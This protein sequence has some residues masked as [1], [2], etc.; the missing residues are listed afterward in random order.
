MNRGKRILAFMLSLA[1]IFPTPSRTEAA[2]M[3]QPSPVE[4]EYTQG[5]QWMISVVQWRDQNKDNRVLTNNSNILFD[6]RALVTETEVDGEA[7]YRVK[8]GY[9]SYSVFDTVEA[10]NPEKNDEAIQYVQDSRGYSNISGLDWS[11]KNAKTSKEEYQFPDNYDTYI[12]PYIKEEADGLYLT[13]RKITAEEAKTAELGTDELLLYK[14]DEK[15]E[16]LAYAMDKGY[17][18]FLIKDLGQDVIMNTCYSGSTLLAETS[19]SLLSFDQYTMT[20]VPDDLAA[21]ETPYTMGF[22]WGNYIKGTVSTRNP[23]GA[24]AALGEAMKGLLKE[25]VSVKVLE[26]GK[27]EATFTLADDLGTATGMDMAVSRNTDPHQDGLNTITRMAIALDLVGTSF[28]EERPLWD[29]SSENKTF[30][31]TFDNFLEGKYIRIKDTKTTNY[32]YGRLYLTREPQYANIITETDAA[33][34]MVLTIDKSYVPEYD[35]FEA[36][37]THRAEESSFSL[38]MQ[39]NIDSFAEGEGRYTIY[40]YKLKDKEGNTLFPTGNFTVDI[41]VPTDYKEESTCYNYYIEE[42]GSDGAGLP[43]DAELITIGTKKYIRLSVKDL[44]YPYIAIGVVDH[45]IPMAAEKISALDPGFYKVRPILGYQ[46]STGIPPMSSMATPVIDGG[47][48]VLEVTA[49]GQKNL[50][51][52]LRGVS[53]LGS[54]GYVYEWYTYEGEDF[55]TTNTAEALS[56]LQWGDL[57][58]DAQKNSNGTQQTDDASVQVDGFTQTLGIYYPRTIKLSLDNPWPNDTYKI[59]VVVPVMNGFTSGGLLEGVKN[60]S[61]YLIEDSV[62]K[63]DGEELKTYTEKYMTYEKSL[64]T[65]LIYRVEWDIKENGR[66]D[67][68]LSQVLAEIK[69]VEAGMAE[70][71]DQAE[72]LNAFNKL[73]DAWVKA[74]GGDQD[75]R[76]FPN[77]TYGVNITVKDHNGTEQSE[78][79]DSFKSTAYLKATEDTM[80]LTLYKKEGAAASV[81]NILY[82]EKDAE[83]IYDSEENLTGFVLK[84]P[85]TN[86]DIP[87]TL[88]IKD[89]IYTADVYVSMRLQEEDVISDGLKVLND[90][91][92]QLEAEVKQGSYE[93]VS[94]E[95][96]NAALESVRSLSAGNS[97]YDLTESVINAQREAL[98]AE[99]DALVKNSDLNSI[100]QAQLLSNTP[101]LEELLD[102]LQEADEEEEEKEKPSKEE[103]PGHSQETGGT[104]SRPG[105]SESG[106]GTAGSEEE[107]PAGDAEEP[108]QEAPQEDGQET[109]DGEDAS[110]ED[111]GNTSEDEESQDASE[112]EESQ[113]SSEDE[114]SQDTSE[115]E[116]ASGDSQDDEAEEDAGEDSQASED[117]SEEDDT[118][119]GEAAVLSLSPRKRLV[120]TAASPSNAIKLE[121]AADTATPPNAVYANASYDIANLP[122][123]N[124][125]VD[126]VLRQ[127]AQPNEDSMGNDAIRD[128]N[129]DGS[130]KQVML[131]VKQ[132]GGEKKVYLHLEF[133]AMSY[134]LNGKEKTGHLLEM[135][136]MENLK[137]NNWNDAD[138]IP[139]V[140]TVLGDGWDADLPAGEKYPDLLVFDIT[141]W[142]EKRTAEI[143]VKV[144]VP[145]MEASAE[146]P[147]LLKFYWNTLELVE[148]VAGDGVKDLQDAIEIAKARLQDGTA[149][150]KA[151]YAALEKS[152][153]AASAL[154]GYT[155][156]NES[157]SS[158]TANRLIRARIKAL[159]KTAAALV[160]SKLEAADNSP[161]AASIR[162]ADSL[163]SGDYTQETWTTM[164][165]ALKKA[166]RVEQNAGSS[167]EEINEVMVELLNTMTSLEKRPDSGKKDD[168]KVDVPDGYYSVR[169]RLWHS[170]MDKASMGDPAIEGKA[171]VH[172]EGED[173]TMRLV[174]KKMTTSGI[175]T[176]LYDFYTDD[177]TGKMDTAELISTENQ[178]WIYEFELPSVGETY[179]DVEVDPRVDVMGTDPVPARLKVT[180]SR[181]DTIT[182]GQ[183]DDLEGDVNYSDGKA[184]S[185]THAV[186]KLKDE[187]TGVSVTGNTGGPG[188]IVESQRLESGETYDKAQAAVADVASQLA[189]WDIKLRS[190]EDYVQ[191]QE[192]VTLKVPIPTAFNTERLLLYRIE[193]DGTKTLFEG[194]VNG[195]Y[196]EATVDHFS[197]YV[198]VECNDDLSVILGT[199][200][201]NAEGGAASAGGTAALAAATASDAAG[202]QGAVIQEVDGRVVPYTGDDTP[203]ELMTAAAIGALA[204]LAATF[205]P[206]RRKKD[207]EGGA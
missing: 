58:E 137:D 20:E 34:G 174:T 44:A 141:N 9:S 12:A 195:S 172:I 42:R 115:D 185:S 24:D 170:V 196:Y 33:T 129:P 72:L 50:Y 71:P 22:E 25:E 28:D 160:V 69:G 112:G 120:L 175:T 124:Y 168:S 154:I 104:E 147:A 136:I 74:G 146:Q 96:F 200:Q 206:R 79:Q 116:E 134:V 18:E 199:K 190:G 31:L 178:Q 109:P 91:A 92:D 176:H 11:K 68:E 80:E 180:W 60:A 179:Y 75:I 114:E 122:E 113:D 63:L 118:A 159:E 47:E 111:S 198:L 38:A 94:L 17:M 167:Q 173:A 139:P 171:Y 52:N 205:M 29:G 61:L 82:N 4:T 191:P 55:E 143:P 149:Y 100:L 53:A 184:T 165:T 110:Q 169:V 76:K 162:L 106:G 155:Y 103:K 189:V 89:S 140:E 23:R 6:S 83:K 132:S 5:R 70:Q 15:T 203:V 102:Q 182:Q 87:M 36:L 117:D 30:T 194:Q 14:A 133:Q 128:V 8:L 84:F 177:G 150:T 35:H 157:L 161:L 135:V 59:G 2:A 119:G 3:R 151:S 49:D 37:A 188:V 1:L 73:N 130:G 138:E 148:N 54:Y 95:S 85:Y 19:G 93:P 21:S 48:G 193:D 201:P 98:Q 163:D 183:W 101:L 204:I 125:Y 131:E 7:Y 158:E 153:E 197:I 40:Q 62:E 127:Y 64:L 16:P 156:N 192:P 88:T 186:S 166:R 164:D 107:E 66:D 65:G 181:I 187:T 43:D 152:I 145:A 51:M 207:K 142:A 99:Y 39:Q 32:R 13:N 78:Y 10:V 56:V 126:F 121:A 81:E 123:G 41:P 86:E 144:N 105:T 108:S 46:T 90:L 26:D 27:L 202:G 67:A 57:T 97:E 77:G 45:G